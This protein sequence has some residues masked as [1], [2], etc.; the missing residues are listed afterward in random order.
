MIM[1]KRSFTDRRSIKGRRKAINFHCLYYSG[2]ERRSKEDRRSPSEKRKG[3]VRIGKW[4][5]VNLWDLKIARFL[6]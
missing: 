3:W 2:K 6:K 4:S 1:E 5:S